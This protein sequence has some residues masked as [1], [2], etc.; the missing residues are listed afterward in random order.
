MNLAKRAGTMAA[1][2]LALSACT[3]V[4]PTAQGEKVRVLSA[5]EVTKCKKVGQTTVS[6]LAKLAGI[7]RNPQKVQ[8]ELNILARN[9]AVELDGDTVV[10]ISAVEDGKQTFAVYRCVPR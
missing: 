6:L 3:W 1:L 10:P 2:V 9:S 5:E 7:E 4:E 8:E